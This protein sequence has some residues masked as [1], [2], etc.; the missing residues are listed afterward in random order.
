M[1]YVEVQLFPSYGAPP[2]STPGNPDLKN[3]A[4]RFAQVVA[5]RI[6]PAVPQEPSTNCLLGPVGAKI[7]MNDAG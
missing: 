2:D 3:E 4:S 1:F 5:S 7:V 6:Q